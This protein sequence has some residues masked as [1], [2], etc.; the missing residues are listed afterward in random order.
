M[1]TA[2]VSKGFSGS[3]DVR[4]SSFRSGEM[5]GFGRKKQ[6]FFGAATPEYA[7]DGRICC[8]YRGEKAL[9]VQKAPQAICSAF[10]IRPSRDYDF[11]II[12]S[13]Q[14][15]SFLVDPRVGDYR[16]HLGEGGKFI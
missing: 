12:F 2:C 4:L 8:V 10:C 16:I 11:H 6:N 3:S 14:V 1:R 7:A 9:E 5:I 15:H 13:E